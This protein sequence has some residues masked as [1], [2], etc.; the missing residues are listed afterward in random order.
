[1]LITLNLWA[2]DFL[3]PYAEPPEQEEEEEEEGNYEAENGKE[4]NTPIFNEQLTT[5]NHRHQDMQVQVTV[6]KATGP[7]G[8]YDLLSTAADAAPAVLPDLIILNPT[9][10]HAAIQGG[11]VQPLPA[12]LPEDDYF[13]F[14]L[15][16][17]REGARNYGFPYVV[18]ADHMV[19]RQGVS[20]TSPLTWTS[21]LSKG[22]TM[23]WPAA[24]LDKLADDALLAAYL[25]TG[26][27]V[28]DENGDPTLE[29]ENLEAL[30]DFFFQLM[31]R[32]QIDPERLLNQ[33]DATACW[34]AYQERA[35][36]VSAAPAGRYWADPPA[37]T[38]PSWVPT[39]EGDPAGIAHVWTIA[40]VTTN[41]ARQAAAMTLAQW[42][43]APEQMAL[44]TRSIEMLPPRPEAVQLWGLL[45][46][47]A[48][49]LEEFL[50]AA[51]PPLR[52]SIDKPV[53][54]AL[55]AGLRALLTGEVE[56]PA[57]AAA[58]A[59]GNLRQ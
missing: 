16:G 52:T 14:A 46:E 10:L 49:F 31:A 28:M 19:Y 48:A 26:G 51:S 25:S 1:G 23:L 4:S 54:R 37:N 35:A 20:A 50:S 9:D 3:D 12:T 43:T 18:Q 2:P 36:Q 45:P 21:V 5:F 42:L 13:P 40:L 29:R 6:K 30:Y 24:P 53:R 27:A 34:E 33:P 47:E 7:G 8:L 41:P 17:Q 56:T 39:P 59:L 38:Q 44:L 57:A 11:Y 15:A 32:D 55:Q 22:Y 58:H